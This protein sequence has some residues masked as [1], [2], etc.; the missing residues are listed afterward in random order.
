MKHVII[1]MACLVTST[2]VFAQNKD[3]KQ[4]EAFHQVMSKTYHP[5][6]EGNLQPVKDNIDE[7][8]KKAKAWQ[9]S[10]VPAAYKAKPIKPLLDELVTESVAIKEAVAQKKDDGTLKKMITTA[11]NTFHEIMEKCEK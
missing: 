4:M 8:I 3:W 10:S 2:V 9:S 1:A 5:A 7:L 11:H 6:E